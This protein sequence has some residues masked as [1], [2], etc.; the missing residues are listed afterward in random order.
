MSRNTKA[1]NKKSK[2]SVKKI[3]TEM[4]IIDGI[5]KSDLTGLVNENNLDVVIELCKKIKGYIN[6][7]VISRAITNNDC[8]EK[9]YNFVKNYN[10]DNM[11]LLYKTFGD[12]AI[13]KNHIGENVISDN[14]YSLFI[15]NKALMVKSLDELITLFVSMRI[16]YIDV[17]NFLKKN[18]FDQ[19]Y[20][21]AN[22][23]YYKKT[24][25]NEKPN[26]SC[27]STSG[28]FNINYETEV[29]LRMFNANPK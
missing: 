27:V 25:S 13:I 12:L 10:D 8:A 3:I 23:A 28:V 6:A 19:L 20:N 14:I 26:C 2:K 4:D 7:Y 21:L 16:S 24:F 9:F 5:N 11:P 15:I 1:V 29:V 18:F 17:L 22:N